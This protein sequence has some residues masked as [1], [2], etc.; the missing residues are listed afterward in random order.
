MTIEQ[1]RAA[2]QASPEV[3]AMA[4]A[5]VPDE[6]AIA[7]ALPPAITLREQFVTER[8]VVAALGLIAGESFLASLE[9]FAAASLYPGHPLLAYQGGI[10]RQLQWLKRDGIDVGSDA[11]RAMLD[12]LTAVG[13][14]NGADVAVI[15]GLAEVATPVEPMA[16]RRAIFNDD[17]SRAV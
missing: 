17:G 9:A 11:A 6:V 14:L 7:A 10:A 16:V 8:G 13:T 2:I 12:A 15:K 4:Q 3:L 1:I 5:A